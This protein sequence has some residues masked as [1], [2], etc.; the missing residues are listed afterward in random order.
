VSP[1]FHA[2]FVT[3]EDTGDFLLVGFAD[4]AL[5]VKDYLTLQ[6]AHEFDEQDRRAGMAEVYIERNDQLFSLYGGMTSF[7]LLPDRI[8][9]QF[10]PA[11]TSAMKGL[12]EMV[13]TFQL[14]GDRFDQLRAGLNRCFTGFDYFL[15]RSA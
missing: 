4:Q 15:D 14:A 1:R 2:D 11:G 8:Y 7:E 12:G 6:R 10:N 9:V 13:V 5:E 3:V